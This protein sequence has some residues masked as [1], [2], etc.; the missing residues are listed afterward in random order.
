MKLR[1]LLL[2]S[3]LLLASCATTSSIPM[4]YVVGTWTGSA[5]QPHNSPYP[6]HWVSKMTADGTYKLVT[7]EE[8]PCGLMVFSEESGRWSISNGLETMV[9]ASVNGKPVNSSESYFQDVYEII[10]VS[11]NARKYRSITYGIELE[12]RRVAKGYK[13]PFPM[14]SEGAR[15]GLD[16]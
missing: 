14:C 5:H 15:S 8:R 12:S 2:L 9:T 13:P 1:V 16:L 4:S 6:I 11:R 10:K 3:V 7:Y